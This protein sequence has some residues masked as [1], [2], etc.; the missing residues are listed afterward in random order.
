MADVELEFC[1][2][3]VVDCFDDVEVVQLPQFDN[4]QGYQ[5]H[6]CSYDEA[7][8]FSRVFVEKLAIV[9]ISLI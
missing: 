4:Q 7:Y 2:I 6:Q 1:M 3:V 9:G 8:P 5:C